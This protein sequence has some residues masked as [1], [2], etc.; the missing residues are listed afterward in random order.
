MLKTW[1]AWSKDEIEYIKETYTIIPTREIAKHLG[2][3]YHSIRLRAQ[4]LG[5]IRPNWNWNKKDVCFL[6]ENYGIL[7]N[8]EIER[9][10]NR[11]KFAIRLKANEL[12]LNGIRAGERSCHW[13]GDS[14]GYT[15]LHYRL[16]NIRGSP[17]KCEICGRTEDG[18]YHEWANLT[19]NYADIY[20][21]KRMC[22]SCH[23]RFDLARKK[24]A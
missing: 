2:R 6:K 11:S 14:A 19:G 21:Y 12:G 5:I 3:S 15:A 18:L 7:L 17:Q 23:R 13:K 10:L 20:D 4:I 24:K 8:E 16:R 9:L 1:K 22:R